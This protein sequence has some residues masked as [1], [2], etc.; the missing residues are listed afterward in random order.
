M[1]ISG[2]IEQ[3]AYATVNAALTWTPVDSNWRA[4]LWGRNLTD[5]VVFEGSTI[6]TTA[7][8]VFYMPPRMFGFDLKY[9]F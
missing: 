1:E 2:R 4:R 7:D 3:P 9:S 6:S 8:R 5:K